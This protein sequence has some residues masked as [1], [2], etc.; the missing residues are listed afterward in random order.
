MTKISSR[1]K[2]FFSLKGQVP[3]SLSLSTLG[4]L[5]CF[6]CGVDSTSLLWALWGVIGGLCLC[7]LFIFFGALFKGQFGR[8]QEMVS[9]SC[10]AE[11]SEHE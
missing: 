11:E 8:E 10:Q 3:P 1:V 4:P 2:A 6:Y 9:K 7:S 5:S